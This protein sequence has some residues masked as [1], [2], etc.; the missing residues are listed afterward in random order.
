MPLKIKSGLANTVARTLVIQASSCTCT[1]TSAYEGWKEELTLTSRPAKSNSSLTLKV[2][3][4][5]KT[6]LSFEFFSWEGGQ[7]WWERIRYYDIQFLD[8]PGQA[9]H[10]DQ[11]TQT[12]TDS[13]VQTSELRV[14]DGGLAIL[15]ALRNQRNCAGNLVLQ[16]IRRYIINQPG[17]NT[18]RKHFKVQ[19]GVSLLYCVLEVVFI[20]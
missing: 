5:D 18:N 11:G 2:E 1:C 16:S 7:Q 8:I 9:C 14:W 17:R 6:I 3:L 20:V 4:Y 15:T 10:I 13:S 19:K 12:C